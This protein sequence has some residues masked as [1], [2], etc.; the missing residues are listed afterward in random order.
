MRCCFVYL[1]VDTVF[2]LLYLLQL[3]WRSIVLYLPHILVVIRRVQMNLVCLFIKVNSEQDCL[4][5]YISN[6]E[7][8]E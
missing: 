7:C 4:K 2:T 1:V 8:W 3:L 5:F 6:Y